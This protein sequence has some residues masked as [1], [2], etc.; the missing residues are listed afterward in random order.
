[1]GCCFSSATAT[2]AAAKTDPKWQNSSKT[3]IPHFP[4]KP[5]VSEP[6]KT[7]ALSPP[8]P[9]KET[10]KDV[11]VLSDT[12]LVRIKQEENAQMLGI[13]ESETESKDFNSMEKRRFQVQKQGEEVS[14]LSEVSEIYSMTETIS[15]ATTA[16][17]AATK[18]INEDEATSKQSME[19]SKRSPAKVPRK[20]SYNVDQGGARARRLESKPSLE[21]RV[22]G[23]GCGS[24]QS[25]EIRTTQRSLGSRSKSPVT[26]R[27][28]GAGAGKGVGTAKGSTVRTSPAKVTRKASAKSMSTEQDALPLGQ[29]EG[30]NDSVL[31]GNVSLENPNV[32]LE[33]FIF[34]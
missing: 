26:A 8:S 1:M 20:R 30:K 2:T 3:K 31:E 14:G 5:P 24:G 29:K 7:P 17:T 13:Q 6:R 33:C 27:A 10:V 32:S 12:P 28:N 11:L 16:T 22:R 4:S 18:D 9:A 15:T 21:K 23:R 25:G 19:A 34:L